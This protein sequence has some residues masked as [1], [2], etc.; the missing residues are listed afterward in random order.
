EDG[1]RGKFVAE[2]ED[3]GLIR[4]AVKAVAANS[5]VVIAL[6]QRKMGGD[7]GHGV[8]KHIVETGELAGIRE[9]GLCGSDEIERLRDMDGRE[10][11]SFLES[12]DELGG[13]AL[14]FNQVWAA[15]NDAMAYRSRRDV[16]VL[17]YNFGDDFQGMLLGF[18]DGILFEV[19]FAGRGADE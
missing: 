1:A 14:M 16:Q 9:G 3:E 7:F 18:V 5:S 6:R 19:D 10:M 2:L 8:V 12:F 4:Q 13:D 17:G 11:H 15:V